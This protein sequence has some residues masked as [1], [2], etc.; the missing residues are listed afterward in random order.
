VKR[1]AYGAAWRTGALAAL[2]WLHRGRLPILCYHS[3]VD[4]SEPPWAVKSGGLHLPVA[5]FREQ[6]EFLAR[7][8]HVVPLESAV[9]ELA[10]GRRPQPRSV[11]LTFD[12][13]YANNLTVAAPLLAEYGFPATIFLATDYVGQKLFWWDDPRAQLEGRGDLLRAATLDERRRLLETWGPH[14]DRT[15]ALRP[16]TWDECRSAPP[17]IQFGGHSAAHRLL[18]EIP[19]HEARAELEAC[20]Q[21]LDIEL[22]KRA[23]PLFCYPA[24]QWTDKIRAAL[25]AAGFRAAVTAGP[26]RGDQRLAGAADD[27]TL[28]PRI[29]VS[30]AMTL[31]VFAGNVAGLPSALGAL[32]PSP[33]VSRLVRGVTRL[34]HPSLGLVVARDAVGLRGRSNGSAAHLHATVEW[35]CRA[36]DQGAGGGV[37]A[38]YSLVDGWLAPYPETT[39]YIIPTFFDYAR[40]FGRGEV[41][42]R[43]IRMADWEIQ[44]QL[45]SGAVQAGVYRGASGDRRPAVFNT[46]QVILGWC[47]AYQETK[48]PRYLEAALR[49]GNWLAQVQAADGAWWLDGPETETVVHA[50]DVRTAWSLLELH[51]LVNDGPYRDAARRNVEWTLTQQ[52]DNGWFEHNAFFTSSDKWNLPLTH[53]IAYVLEGLLGAWEHL[54]DPR[55]LDAV[56]NTARQLLDVFDRTGTLP[57]EFDG[58]W[59]TQRRYSCLTGSAQVAG[60]WLRLH[61]ITGESRWREAAARLNN[62]VKAAQVLNSRHAGVRGGVKGSQPIFGR[63]TPF[64]YIN[65]GA[66]FLADSLMLEDRTSR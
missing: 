18:G 34:L 51:A 28:L 64:T 8:Y 3:V 50:Y 65:W 58:A 55:C 4:G 45:P 29:G 40:A 42:A 38:G 62:T 52:R 16:A 22:G 32:K 37:S 14:P 47:R 21:A 1:A 36:Q 46:G 2:R 33:R 27:L 19:P 63:Y 6:L 12:D 53:T 10:A 56:L 30:S 66:K 5:Q 54:R 44:V 41:R 60:L 13:G 35:L 49:G 9:A 31:T 39:G 20:R 15:D 43:A 7:H 57:G 59:R 11:V 23:V 25:P 48:D 26:E 17:N 24:G 61:Q